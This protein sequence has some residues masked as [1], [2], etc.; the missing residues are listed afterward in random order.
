MPHLVRYNPE[1]A[2]QPEGKHHPHRL[3][4]ADP[5]CGCEEIYSIEGEER[6]SQYTVLQCC[7]CRTDWPCQVQRTKHLAPR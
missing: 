3:I 2:C 4:C 7:I 6:W 1:T 5:D